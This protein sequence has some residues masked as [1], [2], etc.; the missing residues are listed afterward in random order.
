MKKDKEKVIGETFSTEKLSEFLEL[1]PFG[2]DDSR[3][4]ED[5]HILLKAY[6]GLPEEGFE[7]FLPLYQKAGRN[8]NATSPLNETFLDY[9][10]DNQNQQ[11]YVEIMKKAGALTASEVSD[12]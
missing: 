9:I 12:A 4:E 8:I 11:S 5:F 2:G 10:S 3:N 6:R 7:R 1:K